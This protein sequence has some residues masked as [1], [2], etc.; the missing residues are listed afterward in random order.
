MKIR[1]A[2]NQVM[3]EE[4]AEANN[5]MVDTY[6]PQR[7]KSEIL[8]DLINQVAN[9][10]INDVWKDSNG[11]T[12]SD[13]QVQLAGDLDEISHQKLLSDQVIGVRQEEFLVL[14]PPKEPIVIVS[15][16][17]A[18]TKRT[19]VIQTP[20][21]LKKPTMQELIADTAP[22]SIMNVNMNPQRI[23]S[24]GIDGSTSSTSGSGTIAVAICISKTPPYFFSCNGSIGNI[25]KAVTGTTPYFRDTSYLHTSIDRI[26]TN[27]SNVPSVISQILRDEFTIS[28]SRNL[29]SRSRMNITAE[30]VRPMVP[31]LVSHM[32]YNI[33][34][35]NE[36]Y[37]IGI[38]ATSDIRR[39]SNTTHGRASGCV[40]GKGTVVVEAVVNYK[41]DFEIACKYSK[42]QSK[43]KT[44]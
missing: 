9:S 26:L 40:V 4:E 23:N 35:L 41:N 19:G 1:V 17:P 21:A 28:S 34:T 11:A 3:I 20:Q 15:N 33:D 44:I 37:G 13:V 29:N 12:V 8:E 32:T 38:P 30:A 22:Y 6:I 43:Q 14:V 10:T 25:R 31:Q 36:K 27:Y 7:N 2:I 24:T 16:Q 42:L 5:V 39:M 18:M